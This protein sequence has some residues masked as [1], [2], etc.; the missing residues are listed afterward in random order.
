M[1]RRKP[2]KGR[3][4]DG[5][6]RRKSGEPPR[7][8]PRRDRAGGGADAPGSSRL[9]LTRLIREGSVWD[10]YV[11]TATQTGGRTQ[12]RLEFESAGPAHRRTRCSRPLSPSLLEALH[13]GTPVSRVSLEE[14]LTLALGDLEPSDPTEDVEA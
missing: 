14:E 9:L 10:V 4:R 3:R 11:A 5:D 7:D 1:G 2:E 12:T 6:R 13:K 8:E